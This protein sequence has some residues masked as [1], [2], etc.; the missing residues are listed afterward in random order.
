MRACVCARVRAC[1]RACVCCSPPRPLPPFTPPPQPHAGYV[2]KCLLSPD[3][4]Q[5][6]TT[7][8]D[9]TVKLWNLD[10]FTLD[11]TLAGGCCVCVGGGGGCAGAW[12]LACFVLGAAMVGAGSARDHHSLPPPST[13]TP[14]THTHPP[15][16]ACR[17]SPSLMGA[18]WPT[19]RS[20]PPSPST[21]PA[22][23]WASPSGRTACSTRAATS[24][25]SVRGGARVWVGGL[26]LR[27]GRGGA[28]GALGAAL[29]CVQGKGGDTPDHHTHPPPP[30]PTRRHPRRVPPR[31]QV[32]AL[33]P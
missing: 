17:W 19:T 18:S 7:S 13:H 9:R 4:R 8:S 1:V 27:G 25:A 6:A 33:L 11:R 31:P 15:T 30:P 32:L 23:G 24:W 22:A 26:G 16:H 20:S 5:L 3:V 2:L 12:V 14:H 21:S 28:R 10:G 29:A